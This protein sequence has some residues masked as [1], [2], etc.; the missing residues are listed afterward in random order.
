MTTTSLI[1]DYDTQKW[2]GFYI[3]KVFAETRNVK[4]CTEI[5]ASLITDHGWKMLGNWLFWLMDRIK[6]LK[7]PDSKRFYERILEILGQEVNV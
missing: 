1:T 5:T 7:C 6:E 4:A 3:K 2:V